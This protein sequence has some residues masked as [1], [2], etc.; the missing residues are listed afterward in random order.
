MFDLR[1]V[2]WQFV[3]LMVQVEDS[4][5]QEKAPDLKR[6][7]DLWEDI[8]VDLDARLVDLGRKDGDA[9]ADLM[10]NQEVICEQVTAEDKDTVCGELAKVVDSMTA[11]LAAT[12]D[13]QAVEELSFEREE[14][15]LLMKD[16]KALK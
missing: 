2:V 9:F 15:T 6:I 4:L 1:F 12:D 3:R 8:W 10:M 7:Y 14:L 16:L 5:K 11:Q 13:A